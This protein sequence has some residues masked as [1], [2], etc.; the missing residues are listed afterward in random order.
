[1]GAGH[2]HSAR[3]GNKKGLTIALLITAGIMVLEFFGGLFTNSLALL[4]DAGHMLSDVTSLGLSLVA[5]W[6]AARPPTPQKTY[7]Y[8]RLE[9]LAAFLNGV[10]LFAIAGFIAWEAY[11]RLQAPPVVAGA[12]MI[13]ISG[14]GLAA[15]AGSALVLLRV[16]DIH[17]SVNVRS[18]YIHILS[19]ALGSIGAIVAGLLM[20][21][22]QWYIA[23]P[24]ISV[25][26]ALLIF[27]SAWGVVNHTVH[28]LL[29]GTPETVDFNTVKAVLQ[30]IDGVQDVHDLHIWTI[31]SGL[32]SLSC[33]LLISPGTDG[34]A[35]LRD[36]VQ[37]VEQRFHIL[38]TTIQVEDAEL[39]NPQLQV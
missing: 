2:V 18:A 32:D 26:V 34:Q 15:N 9:I 5:V 14:I 21:F 10:T 28:V 22:F 36:A 30:S 17:G 39:N 24:I 19:D 33:H 35:V 38:H 27:R 8:Y 25:A 37:V 7:G 16:S 3:E 20:L 12:A 23:D 6:L 4:S 11:G 13:V 1:M 29:E 31:T